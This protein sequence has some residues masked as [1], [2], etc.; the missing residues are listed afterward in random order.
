M[1]KVTDTVNYTNLFKGYDYTLA[2]ELKVI[3]DKGKVIAI[4]T[5]KDGLKNFTVSGTKDELLVSGSQNVTFT[6]DATGF[7]DKQMVV[8]E[9]LYIGKF[10]DR[11]KLD[12]KKLVGAHEDST[13]KNQT[14]DF[15]VPLNIEKNE[16]GLILGGAKMEIWTADGKTCLESWE[17]VEGKKHETKIRTSEYILREVGAPFGY[18]L[19]ADVKFTVNAN[20]EVVAEGK[21]MTD[22]LITM[23]DKELSV[24]P[25]TG[26]RGSMALP[27]IG[28]G[29]MLGGVIVVLSGKKKNCT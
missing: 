11:E 1:V 8:Y 22:N 7:A 28:L 29:M 5:Q 17:T 12:G 10:T 24:L 25:S 20:C 18:A 26:S 15:D 16:D 4:I 14:F 13:D 27:M 19:A 2:A 6:F 3:D 23:V 21:A 9:K